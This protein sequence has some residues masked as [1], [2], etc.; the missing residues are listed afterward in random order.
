[1]IPVMNVLRQYESLKE[2][3]DQAA[4]E[5]LH[6]GQYI[7]GKTVENFER[8]FA[9]YC[10]TKYAI[11]VANG[12]DALVIALKACGVKPGDE[13]ITCAMS[14][15]STA[16]SIAALGAIPVFVDCTQDTY[17]LDVGKIEEKITE[18]TKAI[19][20]IHLYGQCADMDAINVIANRYKLKV[21]EDTA[22]GTGTLYKGKKAGSI[23]DVGCISFFPTKNL[24]AAGDGGMIITDHEDIYRQC[25]ALRVH[26]SGLNGLFTYEQQNG[27]K[28]S[29]DDVDF[30]GNLPKYYNFVIG[31]NSRLDALQAAILRVKLAYLDKWNSKRREIA[32]QYNE[33]I[34]NPIVVKPYIA[35]YNQPIY[36]VYVMTT[37]KRDSLRKYLEEKGIMTGVY[38]PMPLHLQ[39]AFEQL[40]YKKGDMPN[41][42]YL[43]EHS[44]VIPMFP[45]LRQEEIDNVIEAINEWNPDID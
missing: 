33:K 12:T 14:F 27:I 45:E 24:G 18:K 10:G 26:G 16:E 22:Q 5:V 11:G 36:Y 8:A 25:L 28:T 38:F 39:K 9:E 3:L 19:I 34:S 40:G 29:E 13:V 42:E 4:L 32:K 6:S 44:F 37:E 20:P 1:M 35:E 31:W 15:F 2:E 23:G 43:S 17:L 7:L 30:K 21:I 41:S